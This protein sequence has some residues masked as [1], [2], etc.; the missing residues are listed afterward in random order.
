[1]VFVTL[2]DFDA[3]IIP[4][5]VTIPGALLGL[6]ASL[7]TPLAFRD[8][9]LGS[10]GGFLLLWGIG[11]G[12]HRLTGVEGMGGGDIKLAA[13]LGAFLGWSG[14]LSPCSTSWQ[15]AVGAYHPVPAGWAPR[16]RFRSFLA[17]GLIVE[18]TARTSWLVRARGPGVARF[19]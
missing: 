11:W 7:L 1:M 10:V 13:L 12:Y 6:L 17:A 5:A 14:L 4:D 9:L 18:P 8:A 15:G 2:V 3:R 19:G 16:L